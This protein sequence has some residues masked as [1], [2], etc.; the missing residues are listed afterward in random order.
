MGLKPGTLAQECAGRTPHNPPQPP[1]IAIRP[2]VLAP[3]DCASL[4]ATL[5]PNGI[6]GWIPHATLGTETRPQRSML[7]TRGSRAVEEGGDKGVD[8]DHT[9]GGGMEACVD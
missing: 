2:Y 4:N 5:L 8:T 6:V 9:V 7:L 1:M 3:A